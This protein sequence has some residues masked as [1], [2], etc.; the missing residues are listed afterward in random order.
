MDAYRT[1]DGGEPHRIRRRVILAKHPEI[2]S[3]FGWDPMP[4]YRMAAALLAQLGLAAGVAWCVPRLS[5]VAAAALIVGVGYLVGAVLAH[6]GGVII[7]EAAHD[8]CAPTKT[9]NRLIA[10]FANLPKVFPY[11]MT[12]RRHHLT[13]HLAMGVLGRDDDLPKDVERWAVGNG[14]IRKLLWLLAYPF[15]GAPL[16]S[17]FRWPDRWEIG[18]WMAQALFDGAV[19]YWLGPWALLYLAV[20]TFFSSSLHPIAGHF[21]REHYLWDERQETYSYYGILNRV[22]LNRGYHVEH[23]DFVQ[24][25]GRDLPKLHAIATEYYAHLTSHTSAARVFWTFVTDPRLSHASRFV[26]PFAALRGPLETLRWSSQSA[27][28]RAPEPLRDRHSRP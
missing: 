8:L 16:R 1:T 24:V 21:I 28:D 3:L 9:Q 13:H 18:S 6:Y 10:I 17:S 14:R 26:R 12:F 7:H 4:K 15:A 11:A 23:H 19:V 25:P 2:R 22:T 27:D 5:R 20:S